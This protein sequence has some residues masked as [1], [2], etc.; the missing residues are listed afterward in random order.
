MGRSKQATRKKPRTARRRLTEPDA[1]AARKIASTFIPAQVRASERAS[2]AKLLIPW[3]RAPSGVQPG[4]SVDLDDKGF[5]ATVSDFIGTETLVLHHSLFP[6]MS[7]AENLTT[8]AHLIDQWEPTGKMR[9]ISI[10]T[11]CRSAL[12]SASRAVW[13][14]CEPDRAERRNRAL[15]ITREEV[16]RHKKYVTEQVNRLDQAD[17]GTTSAPM[18]YETPEYLIELKTQKHNAESVMQTLIDSGVKGALTMEQTIDAA[19]EWID[20]N[21]LVKSGRPMANLTR[22]KYSIASGIAHGSTW[23]TR[24][25][26]GATDLTNVVAD[27]LYVS[28]TTT[29]AAITLWETHAS[30][31]PRVGRKCP[32]HLRQA[33]RQLHP[34]YASASS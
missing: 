6:A 4:G 2:A 24:Y 34:R 8:V 33:A 1:V 29:E 13:V 18:A 9:T 21:R 5:P 28:L 7:A 30:V 27:L 22:E 32:Q 14:L 10:I 20:A 25:L 11:L 3:Q 12:E 26:L 15:R 17:A 23:P 19:A 31:D 16:Q